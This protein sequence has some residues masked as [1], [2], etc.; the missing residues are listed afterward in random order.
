MP[1]AHAWNRPRHAG[2]QLDVRILRS[3][4]WLA[5]A[6]GVQAQDGVVRPEFT[7]YQIGPTRGWLWPGR[8]FTI[9]GKNLGPEQSCVRNAGPFLPDG[10]NT[11]EQ[12]AEVERVLP[13]QLC[14]VRVLLDEEPVPLIYVS[15]GQINFV[16]PGSRQFG[17]KVVIRVVRTGA[18]SIPVSLKFGPDRMW[19]SQEQATYT[20]MPVW[21]RLYNVADGR[22]PVEIPFGIS[23]WTN[24]MCPH[25][26]VKFNDA[27]LPELTIKS[28]PRQI[29]YSGNPCPSPQVP[30]RQTLAGRIP[31]HLR[32]RMDRPG[33][34][35]ARYVPGSGFFGTKPTT[36]ETQWTTVEVKPGTEEQRRKW[37]LAQAAAAP[38]DREGLLYDF[39]PS[40]FGY[41][42]SVTLPIAL[43]YLY[44]PDESV[45]ATT[46]G[47][48]RDYYAASELIPALH[49]IEQQ[50]G[51]NRNVDRLLRDLGEKP[52][53]R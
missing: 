48:L 45:S 34:Y 25:I 17:E 23:L 51:A 43:K 50:R 7:A 19:L 13:I 37:L 47:Y 39:L 10:P 31:L 42:D 32:Y 21:V 8:M 9:Y 33:T 16:V 3:A 28:P 15:V 49:R 40:I 22:R 27:P 24:A 18:S 6:L 1:Q 12:L 11:P 29:A 4:V 26:E 38:T 20:G 5:V 53:E 44:H 52:T 46:T 41:G 35:F 36:A 14:G 30:D 2:V